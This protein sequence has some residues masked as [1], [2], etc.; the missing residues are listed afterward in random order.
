M[1]Y[2]I[3][4]LEETKNKLLGNRA[5]QSVPTKSVHCKCFDHKN[6]GDWKL[7]GPCRE[8]LHYLWK[9]AIRIA[10]KPH[11]NYRTL[12]FPVPVVFMVKTFAVYT[13]Q[14]HQKLSKRG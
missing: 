1:K 12:Q 14:K 7:R 2:P 5:K 13:D 6:Y 4:T 10:G 8:N 9:R 11:D 3:H